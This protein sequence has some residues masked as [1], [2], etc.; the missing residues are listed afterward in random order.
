MYF[1]NFFWQI[2]HYL[3]NYKL[4]RQPLTKAKTVR[5]L[6]E[7]Q[8]VPLPASAVMILPLIDVVLAYDQRDL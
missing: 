3:P 4:T 7:K 5:S 8:F 2:C 1:L 6:E